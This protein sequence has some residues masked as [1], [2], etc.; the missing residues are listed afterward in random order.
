MC[1]KNTHSWCHVNAMAFQITENALVCSAANSGWEQRIYQ[2]SASLDCSEGS[3]RVTDGFPSQTVS[4]AKSV[5][6]GLLPDTEIARRMCRDA[7]IFGSLAMR[8]VNN[9]HSWLRHS[10]KSLANRLT[11]DPKIVIGGNSWIILY[12]CPMPWASLCCR[13]SDVWGYIW[14]PWESLLFICPYFLYLYLY[15]WLTRCSLE[16][17][18]VILNI[19]FKLIT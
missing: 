17:A 6:M 18:T 8:F 19:I 1:F 2:S 11:R 9:F 10:W 7:T 12:V 14:Y 16:N 15:P 13:A 4:N 3:L 5:P